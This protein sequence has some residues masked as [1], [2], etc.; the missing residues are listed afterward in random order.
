[1]V[2]IAYL[3]RRFNVNVILKEA[4]WPKKKWKKLKYFTIVFYFV[5]Q[6]FTFSVKQ[7]KFEIVIVPQ[8]QLQHMFAKQLIKFEKCI[9]KN[10][11]DSSF[12]FTK[13]LSQK[14]IVW[15]NFSIYNKI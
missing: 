11:K 6:T 12:P 13:I 15:K 4:G 14:S 9:K 2:M 5:N 10:S 8:Q 1:M 3:P 7:K